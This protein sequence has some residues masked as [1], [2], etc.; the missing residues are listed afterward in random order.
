MVINIATAKGLRRLQVEGDINIYNASEF[1]RQL[2]EQLGA[3]PVVEVNLSR[4][5]EMD[6]AG[7]QVLCL[8]KREAAKNGKAL[9]LVSHSAAVLEVMD[10]YNMAAY[11]GD[12]MV[13]SRTRKKARAPRQRPKGKKTA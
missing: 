4:V 8:A 13:I 6:T 7:F 5:G 9:H 11:F 2:M 12:P 3:A 1:K 10:L